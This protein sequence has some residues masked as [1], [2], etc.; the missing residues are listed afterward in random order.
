MPTVNR[1]IFIFK[2]YWHQLQWYKWFIIIPLL[3]STTVTTSIALTTT[4]EKWLNQQTYQFLLQRLSEADFQIAPN[5]EQIGNGA[6]V[7]ERA[8]FS[9]SQSCLR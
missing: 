5:Q 3:L 7:L 1:G 6:E 9:R 4:N 8:T 2:E